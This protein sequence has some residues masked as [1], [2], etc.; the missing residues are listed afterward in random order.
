MKK[1]LYFGLKVLQFA[2]SGFMLYAIGRGLL[3]NTHEINCVIDEITDL[4]KSTWQYGVLIAGACIICKDIDQVIKKVK[5][6][7]EEEL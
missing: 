5:G 1:V 6:D 3:D 4:I 7:S 2:L